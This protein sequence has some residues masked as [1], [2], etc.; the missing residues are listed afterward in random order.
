VAKQSRF[1]PLLESTSCGNR[2]VR[3][4]NFLGNSALQNRPL[5]TGRPPEFP[6]RFRSRPQVVKRYQFLFRVVRSSFR[7][8]FEYRPMEPEPVPSVC[9]DR[10]THGT[11]QKLSRPLAAFKN[12][13]VTAVSAGWAFRSCS[14]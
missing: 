4:A 1:T 9:S 3:R 8:F 7:E 11:S 12:C 10:Y 5:P 6:Q 2:P 13:A 14:P